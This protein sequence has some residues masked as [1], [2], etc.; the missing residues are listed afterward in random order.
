MGRRERKFRIKREGL[1]VHHIRPSSRGGG[2]RDNLVIL[3]VE[4]H[5]AWHKLFGNMTVEETHRFIA[6]IMQP[7]FEWS[8][9]DIDQLRRRIME[10]K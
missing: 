2:S 6:V 8:Y 4:W 3:P 10:G 1:N 5:A 7:G 9:K